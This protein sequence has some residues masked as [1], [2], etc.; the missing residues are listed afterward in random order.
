[1]ICFRMEDVSD[2]TGIRRNYNIEDENLPIMKKTEVESYIA[3]QIRKQINGSK[4]R[5]LLS[6]SKSLAICLLKYNQYC[7]NELHIYF[8][9]SISPNI[10]TY[11]D[12]KGNFICK[13]YSLQDA[14]NKNLQFGVADRIRIKNFILDLSD[15]NKHI[16]HKII[17]IPAIIM[18]SIFLFF[19]FH[20]PRK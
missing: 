19:I 3:N 8:N 10:I 6:Y 2:I 11:Y 16:P 4:D 18:Y 1:M 5:I 20:H 14:L 7:D 17:A 9:C 12:E 15:N 13:N